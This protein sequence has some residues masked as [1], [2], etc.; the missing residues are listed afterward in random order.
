MN[1]KEGITCLALWD[2]DGRMEKWNIDE[3]KEE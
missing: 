1:V 2:E 3:G